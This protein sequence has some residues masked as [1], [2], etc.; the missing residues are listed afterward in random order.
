MHPELV[1]IANVWQ[2][3]HTI[4]TLK[5]EHEG[6]SA[7]VQQAIRAKAEAEAALAAATA[8][9]AATKDE[10][11]ANTRSLDEYVQKRNAS[12]KMIDEGTAPDYAA[13]TRQWER[14]V[15][16]V[17]DLETK[18]LELL[19]QLDAADRTIRN[20]RHTLAEADTKLVA[21]RAALAARDAPIRSE[22]TATLGA[23]AEAWAALPAFYRSPYDD[24]RRRKRRVLTNTQDGL[25]VQCHMRIPPQR[26]VEVHSLKAVHTCPG[27]QAYLLP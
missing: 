3:D 19:D 12:R 21:A 17:D 23:R 9:F 1:A 26:I 2:R 15:A 13:V 25:C 8:A 14:C 7:A 10:E 18:G 11:R 4:D 27:C 5:A 20:A 16:I 22:L 6:L 24:L